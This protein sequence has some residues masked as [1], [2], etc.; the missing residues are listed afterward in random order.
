[1]V[2]RQVRAEVTRE[3][4]LQGAATI[5]VR[6]GYADA[7][8]GDIIEEAG[9][10]KGAL[11]FHFGSKEELARGVIDS[12]YLRF[13]AAA[14]SKMDRRSPAL[15]TLIDLSVLHVDMSE[16]DSVVRAMFRLLVEIGDYQAPSTGY[17]IWQNNLQELAARAADEATSSRTSTSTRSPCCCSNRRCARIMA[18]ALKAT[19]RLAE[20]TGAMCR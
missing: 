3:S 10:T 11:Y 12:G 15:E 8:L 17:E 5:F 19:E 2:G 14:E 16:T 7:N 9:V 13:E 1:M 20:Q 4:V 6:D 18:N